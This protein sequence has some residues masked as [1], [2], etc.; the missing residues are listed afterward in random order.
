MSGYLREGGY[1]IFEAFSKNHLTYIAQ[2]KEIGGPTDPDM[3]FSI[4]EIKRDFSDFEIM[5]LAEVE[6]QLAEGLYHNGTGSVI[7]FLGRK[8]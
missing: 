1:V 8:K 4:D 5:E 6:V 2:N 7:R 3:L